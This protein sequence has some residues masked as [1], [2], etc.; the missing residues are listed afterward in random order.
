MFLLLERKM[1]ELEQEGYLVGMIDLFPYPALFKQALVTGVRA[2]CMKCV[3]CAPNV[4]I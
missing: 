3:E 1:I 4:W 2:W